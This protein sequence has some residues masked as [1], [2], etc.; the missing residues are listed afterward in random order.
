M[1]SSPLVLAWLSPPM[2]LVELP[3]C[4]LRARC[5]LQALPQHDLICPPGPA[6]Q[7]SYVRLFIKLSISVM[8][9]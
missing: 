5:F 3:C 4:S 7:P 8:L 2:L 1:G 9:A 6:R